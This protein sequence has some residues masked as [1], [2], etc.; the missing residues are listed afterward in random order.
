[1]TGPNQNGE[2]FS[3]DMAHD[4]GGAREP[5]PE[6]EDHLRQSTATPDDTGG[7]YGYDEVHSVP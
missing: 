4:L 7:D 3:Y 6:T 5:T 1:M 2:D